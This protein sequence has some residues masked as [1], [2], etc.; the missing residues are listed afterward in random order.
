MAK[1]SEDFKARIAR[2]VKERKAEVVEEPDF[3]IVPE[4]EE[5]EPDYE[6]EVDNTVDWGFLTD[7]EERSWEE[8]APEP[9][10][11]QLLAEDTIEALAD[12]FYQEGYDAF[13]QGV[14]SANNPVLEAEEVIADDP[15]TEISVQAWDEGWVSGLR[16]KSIADILLAARGLVTAVTEEDA[17]EMFT[18]LAESVEKAAIIIDFDEQEQFW[19]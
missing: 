16:D 10:D 9:T 18:L 5:D 11:E 14:D 17:E 15:A 6:V 19:W 8:D 2:R 13:L 7:I 12:H 1:K 4:D 3:D